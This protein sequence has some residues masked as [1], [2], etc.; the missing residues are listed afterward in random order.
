LGRFKELLEEAI[1]C[2]AQLLQ[3]N[4]KNKT[5]TPAQ[6]AEFLR[7]SRLLSQGKVREGTRFITQRFREGGVLN[8]KDQ[9][10]DKKGNPNGLTVMD[11]LK[12]KHPDGRVPDPSVFPRKEDAANLDPLPEVIVTVEH[13]EQAARRLQGGAGPSG[14]HALELKSWLSNFGNASARLREAFA[15]SATQHA[16]EKVPLDDM[17]AFLAGRGLALDKLPG[18]RPLG[19]PNAQYRLEANAI[20]AICG[21]DVELH[22]GKDNLCGGLRAGIEG[23]FHAMWQ[24]FE[25][26]DEVEAV[27]LMDAENAFNNLNREQALAEVRKVWPRAARFLFNAYKGQKMI[28]VSGT[29]EI[30]LSKEGCTQGDPFAM[31]FYALGINPCF[32]E[33]NKVV[34][35]KGGSVQ[36]VKFADDASAAGKLLDVVSWVEALVDIGPK[37]GYFPEPSKSVLVVKDKEGLVEKAREVFAAFKGLEIVSHHKFLG[38]CVG[39]QAGVQTYV[40]K[41][42]DGWVRCVEHLALAAER[43]P[44]AAYVAFTKSL[45][46]EWKFLQR[47]IPNSAV[48]FKRLND[49]IKGTF[50]PSLVGRSVSEIELRLFELPTRFGGLGILDPTKIAQSS[51][52]VSHSA[53]AMVREAILGDEPLDVPGHRAFYAQ[54][55]RSHRAVVEEG[56]K[57]EFSAVLEEMKPEQ[58]IRVKAQVDS[59]GMAWMNALPLESESFDLSAEQWR[60]RVALQYGWSLKA[61][62]SSCDGCGKKF[63]TDHALMC[64]NG[65]NVKWGHDQVRDV[66]AELSQRAW[67]NCIREPVL[68]EASQRAKDG[69]NDGLIAD[70]CVRGVWERNRDCLFDTRI[71]HAGS[72]G[73]VSRSISYNN[74]LTTAAR[75]KTKKYKVAAEMRR[76]SFCPLI[77]T[78]DGVAHQAFQ[79]FLRRVA[80]QLSAK[81]QRPLSTVTNWVRVRLQFAVIKAVDLRLRGSRKR[82]KSAGFEDGA[83]LMAQF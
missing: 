32:F 37:Y 25:E 42:V 8:P 14:V 5:R 19:I 11:V 67:N 54:K 38:G 68:R 36:E 82:W 70:L 73:R 20:L 17:W 56:L 10:E 71:I 12:K 47:L 48:S 44:Q 63:S 52:E 7:F 79:A 9:A 6:H 24:K 45:Q 23:G 49:A 53:T 30:L 31:H 62:P 41:K 74:A 16:N 26:D 83:G 35:Q 3:D 34:T 27:F 55:Q 81:W 13:I 57:A 64:M 65:G 60:D 15:A 78:T 51:Y 80:A 29:D 39:E 21:E 61:L 66:C 2:N 28:F 50:I 72:P 75:E 43:F 59:K 33:V 4:Q 18:V 77:I 58:R 22:L 1:R 76:A 69:E 40:E 46:S